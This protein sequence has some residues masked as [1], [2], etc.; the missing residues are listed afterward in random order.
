MPLN[1]SFPLSA[2]SVSSFVRFIRAFFFVDESHIQSVVPYSCDRQTFNFGRERHPPRQR[3]EQA[4]RH[5]CPILAS[6]PRRS[7]CFRLFGQP[8]SRWAWS[9]IVLSVQRLAASADGATDENELPLEMRPFVASRFVYNISFESFHSFP[10]ALDDSFCGGIRSLARSSALFPPPYLSSSST[11]LA[12]IY[13]DVRAINYCKHASILPI[14]SWI[15]LPTP[16]VCNISNEIKYSP[17]VN[18]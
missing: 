17:N 9:F 10:R 1:G 7:I 5:R 12:S 3:S 18:K 14:D 4:S 11:S 2:S 15:S 6:L 13:C 16:I 8:V